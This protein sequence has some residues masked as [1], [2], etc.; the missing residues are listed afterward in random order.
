MKAAVVL[1]ALAIIVVFLGLAFKHR[2]DFLNFNASSYAKV[3]KTAVPAIGAETKS[4]KSSDLT[5]LLESGIRTKQG[6]L[7]SRRLVAG[8]VVLYGLSLKQQQLA[9]TATAPIELVRAFLVGEM[10]VMLLSYNQGGTSCSNLYRFLVIN[11]SSYWLSKEFGSCMPATKI[12]ESDGVIFVHIPQ[13]NPYLGPEVKVIYSFSGT[14]LEEVA[15]FNSVQ[16]PQLV[17]A[18][19]QAILKQALADGCLVDGVL[20]YDNACRDGRKYCWWFKHLAQKE[21][22]AA[23]HLLQDFCAS[24]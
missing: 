1:I 5:L 21:D 2:F 17:K 20:L 11:D 4:T 15:K 14:K 8:T 9:L 19:A 18:N 16:Q 13:N 7:Q 22:S 24:P 6:V 12:T 10:Q 3:I 23:Y